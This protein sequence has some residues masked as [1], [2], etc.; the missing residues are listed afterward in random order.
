M[1]LDYIKNN[2]LITDGAMGTYFSTLTGDDVHSCEFANVQKPEVIRDI[3]DSYIEAGAK[4][5][6]TNTFSS[7]SFNLGISRAE[8]KRLLHTGY[9]IAKEAAAGKGVFVA[10]S[11]GPISSSELDK[12]DIDILDEYKFV[13]NSLMEA[14]AD[15]FLFETFSNTDYLAEISE[16]IKKKSNSAVV[17]AHFAIMPDGYSREGISIKTIAKDAKAIKSIDIYGFNCGSGP[18]HLF[19]LIKTLNISGEF[20]SA[21]PNSGYP[22]V[23]NERTVFVNNPVYFADKMAD[24]RDLGV[25]ILGGCC[26][27][28]PEHIREL[29]KRLSEADEEGITAQEPSQ[30][31]KK[32]TVREKNT[33]Q[34]KLLRNEFVFAVEL[35]PPF[36]TDLSKIMDGAKLCKEHGIDL[37]TIADSPMSKVRVDSITIAAKIK[38]EI[39]IDAMP[40][41]CCRDKNIIALRAGLLASHVEGIRNVLAVTGDPVIAEE[42]ASIQ[43]VFNLNSFKLMDLISQMNAEFFAEDSMSIGGA[44]NL[45]VMNKQAEVD[46]MQ[47]KTENGATFFLTQPI[48]EDDAIEFLKNMK[49]ENVKILGGI[50]P[51]VSYRNA[52]FLNNELPGVQVP[53]SYIN[54]FNKKMSREEAEE[55]GVEIAVEI[56]NKIKPYVDGIYFMTPFNRVSM[57][58]KIIEKAI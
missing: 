48:Y 33:F 35:D 17:M 6:R 38:R 31:E 8:V 40:H 56:A 52:Q 26:G 57:I 22:E 25:K 7:N 5:I 20:I 27:T 41:I 51:I 44:L 45:N 10:A 14:G 47:K 18:T 39:G 23:I 28:T 11:I 1:I 29:T 2:I 32:P 19:K 55:V 13:V 50:L 53:E 12:N 37:I 30:S 15:I 3:H 9:N 42:R 43:S 36:D 24:F 21:M 54:R 34:D 49:K 4:L 46:R 16:Y 58:V